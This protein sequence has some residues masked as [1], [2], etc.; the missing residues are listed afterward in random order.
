M[1]TYDTSQISLPKDEA[2]SLRQFT[3]T[4]VETGEEITMATNRNGCGLFELSGGD[5]IQRGGG[6]WEVSINDEADAL[7][8]LQYRAMLYWGEK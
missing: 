3:A 1:I 4:Q 6:T 8:E 7:R 5:C 2:G